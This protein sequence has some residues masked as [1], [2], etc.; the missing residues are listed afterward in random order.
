MDTR[1]LESLEP[2]DVENLIE[3]AEERAKDL[4]IT[5]DYYL[6]EFL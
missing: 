4:E 2:A 6:M 1:K 3:I 5:V